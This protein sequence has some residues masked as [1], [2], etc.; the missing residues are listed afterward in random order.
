MFDGAGLPVTCFSIHL[1]NTCVQVEFVLNLECPEDVLIGRLLQRGKTSG[2]AD[3]SLDVIKKRFQT[4]QQETLPI[5][6]HFQALGKVKTIVSDKPV[7]AV[8][9]EVAGLFVSV[10]FPWEV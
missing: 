1:Y 4:A 5:L 6:E 8:Y 7:E 3:D 9:Q 2:R 10:L